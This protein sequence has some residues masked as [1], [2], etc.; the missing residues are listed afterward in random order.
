MFNAAAD[1]FFPV[2]EEAKVYLIAR[3]QLKTANSKFNKLPNDY[4]LTLNEVCELQS[5]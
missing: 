1:R 3:G 5:L 2:F 4:E